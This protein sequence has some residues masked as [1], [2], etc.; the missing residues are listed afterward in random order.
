LSRQ[1]RA[2]WTCVLL[3]GLTTIGAYGVAYYAIGALIPAISKDTGWSSGT[4]ASAFS[5]ALLLQGGVAL[6]L[7]RLFDR[8]GSVPVLA[9]SL[10]VGAAFLLMASLAQAPWQFVLTWTLGAGA[11]GGGLY[12]NVTMPALARLFP[13]RRATAFSGLTLLGALASPIFYPLAAVLMDSMGW[14]STLQVLV[15][16][17]V[18]CVSPAI[19]LVRAPPGAQTVDRRGRTQSLASTLREPAIA[20]ALLLVAVASFANAAVLLHQVSIIEATGLSLTA[21][22]SYAGLR[23]AFQLPGRVLLSP[24]VRAAGVRGL[25]AGCYV[26]SGT[27]VLAL[28]PALNGGITTVFV[29]YFTVASGVSIGLLSPLNGLFQADVYGDSRLG[30]LSGVTVIVVSVAGAAGSW[31]GGVSVDLTGSFEVLLIGASASQ[32]AAVLVLAW[33]ARAGKPGTPGRGRRP[34]AVSARPATRHVP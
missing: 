27:A 34:R 7:G 5:L 28:V 9:I 6:G 12:Y 22:S 13:S 21:A 1:R 23:G 19:F 18:C 20:R 14:R 10:V 29:L 4:L 15:L 30:T 11:I 16:V 17:L 31:L 8:C 26:L 2:L 3:L 24:L 25:L 33:Q 32:M